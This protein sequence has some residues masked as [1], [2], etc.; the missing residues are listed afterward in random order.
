[1]LAAALWKEK[2]ADQMIS[3]LQDAVASLEYLDK[4]DPLAPLTS[5]SRFTHPSREMG[6]AGE[7]L[8]ASLFDSPLQQYVQA[9]LG[10]ALRNWLVPNRDHLTLPEAA[11]NCYV[12]S[13]MLGLLVHGR[14]LPRETPSI[15]S[16]IERR[17]N[18][19]T[20]NNDYAELPSVRDDLWDEPIRFDTGD[21]AWD[22]VLRATMEEVGRLG[23]DA[24]TMT[25][26]A[27]ASGFTQGA[28]FSRY[29]SKREL[30]LDA[31]RRMVEISSIRNEA[32]HLELI[33]KYGPGIAEAIMLHG[34]M[35]PSR[36]GLQIINLEQFRLAW[37]DAEMRDALQA[38]IDLNVEHVKRQPSTVTDDPAAWVHCE[39]AL[40]L[41]VVLLAALCPEA[42]SLPIHVVTIPLLEGN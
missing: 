15:N 17:W 23:Y 41:G 32:F 19:L 25:K 9:D 1:M 20:T 28:I 40:G 30:F 16:E 36:R 6:A 42:S 27:D 31:T 4:D 2:L 21:F 7:L 11:K 18:A 12:L 24:A 34:F 8:I 26:I 14:A 5:V 3:A 37:H 29:T 39:Y 22:A 13:L 33:E 38:A 35:K 10:E